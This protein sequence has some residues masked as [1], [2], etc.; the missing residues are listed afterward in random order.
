[1]A[2]S[3]KNGTAGSKEIF[4]GTSAT[5]IKK[6]RTDARKSILWSTLS[7]KS[8]QKDDLVILG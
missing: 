2:E 3:M 4:R 1:M 8:Y 6:L 5:R 7:K